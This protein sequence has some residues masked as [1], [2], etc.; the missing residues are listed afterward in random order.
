[1]EV[2]AAKVLLTNE[3]C[4]VGAYKSDPAVRKH[5]DE[6][7]KLQATLSTISAKACAMVA[8]LWPGPALHRQ[9]YFAIETKKALAELPKVIER[10]VFSV[11]MAYQK[12]PTAAEAPTPE[13][14]EELIRAKFVDTKKEKVVVV[15][16]KDFVDFVT[17][18]AWGHLWRHQGGR[19]TWVGPRTSGVPINP[20]RNGRRGHREG[21]GRKRSGPKDQIIRQRKEKEAK[22]KKGKGGKG[23]VKQVGGRWPWA[24]FT[25]LPHPSRPSAPFP[26]PNTNPC[27]QLAAHISRATPCALA[28]SGSVSLF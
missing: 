6:I 9:K 24:V 28:S 5:T 15:R 14:M 12:A 16:A 26:H 22:A 8:P 10:G 25:P 1:M 27:H 2:A 21:R 18:E 7:D 4:E 17:H 20:S 3:V 13:A 11:V 23:F 19:L